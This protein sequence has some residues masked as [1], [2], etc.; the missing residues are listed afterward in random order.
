MLNR[1]NFYSIWHTIVV[2]K[3][4]GGL[5]VKKI[6]FSVFLFFMMVAPVLSACNWESCTAVQADGKRSAFPEGQMESVTCYLPEYKCYGNYYV[7]GCKSC[8]GE[9][10]STEVTEYSSVAGCDVTYRTCVKNSAGGGGGEDAC[11]GAK[12]EECK[13]KCAAESVDW[14][15]IENVMGYQYRTVKKCNENT[16]GCITSHTYRCADNYYGT[17]KCSLSWNGGS[18]CSGCTE[19]PDVGDIYTDGEFKTKAQASSK[20]GYNT[21]KQSCYL[22]SGKYYTKIGNFTVPEN[23]TCDY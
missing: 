1:L 20:A 13:S 15:A 12:L 7:Y 18:P 5:Y 4:V 11:T 19:C 22:P 9:Y 8:G 23:Q 6:L 16:C 14:T 2:K 3:I 21:E 17:A 10:E